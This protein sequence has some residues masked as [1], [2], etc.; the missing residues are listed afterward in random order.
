MKDLLACA[1]L[2]IVIC[3]VLLL[4]DPALLNSFVD[5]ERDVVVQVKQD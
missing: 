4:V 1:L 3:T 5:I 2:A